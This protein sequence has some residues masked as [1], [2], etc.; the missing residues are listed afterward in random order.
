M[1]PDLYPGDVLVINPEQAF[2]NFKGVIGMVKHDE[3]F[4]IRRV[5]HRKDNYPLETSN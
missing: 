5:W 3:S 4:K 2:T 1:V